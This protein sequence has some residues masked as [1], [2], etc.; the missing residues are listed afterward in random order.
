MNRFNPIRDQDPVWAILKTFNYMGTLRPP[1]PLTN[2]P[3]SHSIM[4]KMGLLIK[5]D[6]SLKNAKIHKIDLTEELNGHPLFEVCLFIVYS[7]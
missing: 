5:F 1:L 4:T 3:V 2:L 7:L 6:N